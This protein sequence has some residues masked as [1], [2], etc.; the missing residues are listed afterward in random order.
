MVLDFGTG[1]VVGMTAMLI[2]T[3]CGLWLSRE[4]K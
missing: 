1:V 4:N 2:I 3:I